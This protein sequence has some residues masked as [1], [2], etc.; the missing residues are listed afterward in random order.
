MFN[1]MVSHGEDMIDNP[2]IDKNIPSFKS[3]PKD[4]I[5][6][7][8]NVSGENFFYNLTYKVDEMSEY[9]FQKILS[10]YPV[11]LFKDNIF[12]VF[13]TA[14]EKMERRYRFLRRK[15]S[16]FSV[17]VQ[18]ILTIFFNLFRHNFHPDLYGNF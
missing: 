11:D 7:T 16:L 9:S 15:F 2:H 8:V 14:I 12:E 13:N 4:I 17:N 5:P 3:L 10:L 18:R 1:V 6:L